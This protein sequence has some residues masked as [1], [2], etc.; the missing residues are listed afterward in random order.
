MHTLQVIFAFAPQPLLEECCTNFL[1]GSH[2]SPLCLHNTTPALLSKPS[3]LQFTPSTGL[4]MALTFAHNLMHSAGH[5]CCCASAPAG[6]VL[7]QLP[8]RVHPLPLC[9]HNTTLALLSKPSRMQLAPQCELLLTSSHTFCRSSL[10]L[11]RSPCW[12]S[13]TPTS[14]LET[15][16]PWPPTPVPT[17]PFRP[18]WQLP[19]APLW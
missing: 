6:G 17:L 8:P 9:L 4:A 3:S 14:S 11:R 13:S 15:L 1:F 19:T 10:L 16:Q 12:R 7:P 5:L 18:S 2:P